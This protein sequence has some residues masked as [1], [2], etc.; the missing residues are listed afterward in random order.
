MSHFVISIAH[1]L[2]LKQRTKLE[3]L[4]TGKE[5]LI[6]KIP[7]LL[8][9]FFSE[10]HFLEWSVRRVEIGDFTELSGKERRSF[11]S[12]T[13]AKTETVKFVIYLCLSIG[14]VKTITSLEV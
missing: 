3:K 13:R 14:L 6:G 1:W 9:F 7:F 11:Y 10:K 2:T 5:F 4:A 12:P 8:I